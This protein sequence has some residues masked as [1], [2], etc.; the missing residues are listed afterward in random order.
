MPAD[1]LKVMPAS[2]VIFVP[3]VRHGQQTLARQQG[4]GGRH[5]PPI[6][7]FSSYSNRIWS[8]ELSRDV[9]PGGGF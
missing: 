8:S 6:V 3:I 7:A 2:N 1:H 5:P 9:S 4:L